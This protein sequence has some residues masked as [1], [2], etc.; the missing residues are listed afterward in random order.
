MYSFLLRKKINV[1]YKI[2]IFHINTKIKIRFRLVYTN[3]YL[4]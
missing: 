3:F 2:Y 1:Y 4:S